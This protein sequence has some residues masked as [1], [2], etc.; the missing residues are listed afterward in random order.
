VDDIVVGT[1]KKIAKAPDGSIAGAAG[2]SIDCENFL[3]AF[4]QGEDADFTAAA[5]EEDEFSAVVVKP[6]KSIWEVSATG[7]SKITAPFYAIGAARAILIGAM[8]AGATAQEAV[9]IAVQYDKLCGGTV[10]TETLDA[11]SKE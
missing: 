9:R 6:D 4:R 11:Q 10:D 3:A 7:R 5:R 8:A 1:V 2:N